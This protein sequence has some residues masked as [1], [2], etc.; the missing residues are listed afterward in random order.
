[1]KKFITVAITSLMFTMSAAPVFATAPIVMV[2]NFAKV[3]FEDGEASKW[4]VYGEYASHD[5]ISTAGVVDGS[6]AMKLSMNGRTTDWGKITSLTVAPADGAPWNLAKN[7]IIKATLTNPENFDLSIRI[8]FLDTSGN[9]R[10][11]FFTVPANSTREISITGE[12]FGETGV[13]S[14][15]WEA[16]GYSGKGLDTSAIKEMRFHFPEPEPKFIPGINAASMIIDNLYVEK[17]PA[18]PAMPIEGS[19]FPITSFEDG[20]AK[21]W[22]VTGPS[23]IHEI[24]T[25][26]AVDGTKALK[27]TITERSMNW[28]VRNNLAIIPPGEIWNMGTATSVVAT[29]TNP[30][31]AAIQLRCNFSDTA[32][33]TRMVYFSIPANSTRELV[34]G[35]EQLGTPG[36]KNSKWGADGYDLNGV[37]KSALKGMTFY[38]AEPELKTMP[39]IT[40]PV[41]IIDNITI[42]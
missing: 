34:M 3:S 23:N 22:N 36:V 1:M 32:N 27:V 17:G 4:N 41:Y 39:G 25:E 2:G 10:L 21:K 11:V 19:N 26:G 40:S 12:Y 33:N 28:G 7:D 15:K 14:A 18:E 5:I 16:D 29:V 13:A 20:V 37:D 35:P 42:R 9:N 30:L 24:V 8:N 38:M 6:K 31:D